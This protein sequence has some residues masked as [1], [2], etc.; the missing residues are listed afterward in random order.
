MPPRPS[1][2]MIWYGPGRGPAVGID[3]LF[4][5]VDDVESGWRGPVRVHVGLAV[6]C[7]P[8]LLISPDCNYLGRIGGNELLPDLTATALEI[9]PVD[10]ERI[11][12][13]ATQEDR[14]RID[15]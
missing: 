1:G 13:A 11:L 9:E 10:A 3:S 4:Q 14:T 7:Q 12:L 2:A 5:A 15:A 8:D 6:R